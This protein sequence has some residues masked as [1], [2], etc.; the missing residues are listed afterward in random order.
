MCN[1]NMV[2]TSWYVLYCYYYVVDFILLS[3]QTLKAI[4]IRKIAMSSVFLLFDF[5]QFS[6]FLKLKD[7][8]HLI[9]LE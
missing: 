8:F 3:R 5:L 7:V 4:Q 6:L 9:D 1:D 2:D